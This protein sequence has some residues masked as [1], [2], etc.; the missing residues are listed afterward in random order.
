MGAGDARR[1]PSPLLLFLLGTRSFGEKVGLAAGA[2]AAF[3]PE[4]VWYCA[5]FWSEIVFVTLLWWAFERLLASEGG[6]TRAAAMAGV[7][8]GLAALTRET[9]LFFVPLVCL[10]L[11]R[12]RESGRRRAAVFLLATAAVIAP[13]TARNLVVTGAFVPVA[14]RG[15]FN[16]WL[17][18][19][20]RPWEEVYREY[21][22]IEGGPIAQERHARR[23]AMKAVLDRQPRWLLD[24]LVHETKAFW[25]VNDQIVVHLERQRVQAAARRSEP[26][27]GI[28]SPSFPTWRCSSSRSPPSRRPEA[29]AR[30]SFSWD[31]CS[32]RSSSTWWRS[33]RRAFACLSCPCSSCSRARRSIAAWCRPGGG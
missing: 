24:K 32:S 11:A 19:T 12:G 10:W 21:Q 16:L 5:H 18:N 17:A 7:L 28:S 8:W 3:Y 26:A 13:W 22:A 29:T 30:A 20:L 9:V 15:S 31:S 2:L 4:L 33:L 25:G 14:T 1:A 23:E 27:R 6:D